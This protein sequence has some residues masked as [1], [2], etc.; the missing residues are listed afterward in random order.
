[1]PAIWSSSERPTFVPTVI[2]DGIRHAILSP[3]DPFLNLQKLRG[4][5]KIQTASSS[6][7]SNSK[8]KIKLN[9]V[10]T[11]DL[12]SQKCKD[13]FGDYGFM[14]GNSVRTNVTNLK[15]PRELTPPRCKSAKTGISMPNLRLCHKE[16]ENS[17]S[18]INF[19][20]DKVCRWLCTSGDLEK[21]EVDD[22]AKHLKIQQTD[23]TD[24]G[25]AEILEIRNQRFYENDDFVDSENDIESD[26][27]SI[28]KC[29]GS[30]QSVWTPPGKQELHIFMPELITSRG[31]FASSA[32]SVCS[33]CNDSLKN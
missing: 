33:E 17:T 10:P 29:N 25:E 31:R 28:E 24:K 8:E 23:A 14:I 19:L 21:L 26:T 3:D 22:L 7:S 9:F 18:D 6:S 5:R 16:E 30:S 13:D 32:E 11:K 12:S 2:I 20:A 15:F 27:E 4:S 1:M